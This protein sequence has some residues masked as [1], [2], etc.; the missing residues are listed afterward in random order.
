M[1]QR[2]KRFLQTDCSPVLTLLFF[3]ALL[4]AFIVISYRIRQE[5]YDRELQSLTLA[6]EN[7]ITSCYALEGTYP[8]SLSY[9]EEHYGLTYDAERFFIDYR[10]IG[11]NI[12][13]DY[14]VMEVKQ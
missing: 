12:R 7:D 9:L 4:F 11:A 3:A 13:P 6:V 14:A 8:P 2:I 10:P 1:K 5:S